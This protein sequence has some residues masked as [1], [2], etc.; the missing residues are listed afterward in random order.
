M[1]LKRSLGLTELTLYGIGIILGAGIYAII[2]IGANIAHEGLWISFL[3]AAVIAGLSG[4]SYAEL[5]GRYPK[6]AAEYQYTQRA[7]QNERLAFVIGIIMVFAG[8]VSSAAVSLGF[9]GYL[10]GLF[11]IAIIPGA[12]IIIILLT[13]L[14]FVGIKESSRFNILATFIE[15]AGLV[16]IIALGFPDIG[17]TVVNLTFSPTGMMGMFSAISVIFFAYIGFENL[18]N[19]GEEARNPKKDL[20]RALLLA[21]FIS[22][23]LYVLTAVAAVGVVGWETLAGS[24]APLTEVVIAKGVSWLIPIFSVIAL[25]STGNTVL[26]MMI[27]VSRMMF[28]LA[29]EGHFPAPLG[30]VHHTRRTP[31][32]AVG[33]TGLVTALLII[34]GDLSGVVQLTNASLFLGYFVVNISLIKIRLRD[35]PSPHFTVPGTIGRVPLIPIF[36][37]LSCIGMLLFFDVI[38]LITMGVVVLLAFGLYHIIQHTTGRQHGPQRSSAARHRARR[39]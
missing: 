28:R 27:V 13:L 25:F 35:G 26:I 19:M 29:R 3:I 18:A 21:L 39:R 16:I 5:A 17:T 4:L 7:F 15:F 10:S 38:T 22:T 23:I 9:A 33:L 2:G 31:Y 30:R 34:P 32:V 8:F 6:A 36:G 12:L 1:E 37:A 14:N 11:G 20:P 24:S